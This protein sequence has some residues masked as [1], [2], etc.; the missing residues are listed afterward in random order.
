MGVKRNIYVGC[1]PCRKGTYV[2]SLETAHQWTEQHWAV[3]KRT[4]D[5][6]ILRGIKPKQ[7]YAELETAGEQRPRCECH[8]EPMVW[9][10]RE[11]YAAGGRWEHGRKYP[12]PTLQ[13]TR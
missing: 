2:S 12:V 4:K 6:T 5:F 8:D 10:R 1:L 7:K 13:E 9:T 3:C 11:D